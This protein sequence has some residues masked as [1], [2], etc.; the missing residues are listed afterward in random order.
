MFYVMNIIMRSEENY[1][2]RIKSYTGD[3]VG[4]NEMS[5]MSSPG[6]FLAL[7]VAVDIVVDSPP[8]QLFGPPKVV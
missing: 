1:K 7:V 5:I 8:E 2:T 3:V 6:L 4:L